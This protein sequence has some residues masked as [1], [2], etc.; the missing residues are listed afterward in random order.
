MEQCAFEIDLDRRYVLAGGQ[1]YGL[2]R[3][4]QGDFA[5]V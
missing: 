4:A 1:L 2:D 5:R 3:H